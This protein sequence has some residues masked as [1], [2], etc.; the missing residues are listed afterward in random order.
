MNLTGNIVTLRAIE[1]DDMDFLK[2]MLNDEELERNVVGWAFP[3]SSYEQ[4]NWYKNNIS[5]KSNIRYIVE[6]DQKRIGLATLTD[7]DWKNRKAMH[8]IKLCNEDFR[9][10]GYGTDIV[11][12]IMK[13]AFE[14]LQL[15]RLYGSILD[16]N[17]ASQ[18]LYKKCGWKVEGIQKDSVFKNNA[19]HDEIMVGILKKDYEELN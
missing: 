19:Y 10:K 4:E 15:N 1:I 13:Y 5:N 11:K 2:E 16:Y 6:A 17:I 12:T 3:I 14:E 8:G 7:I 18:K 9:G